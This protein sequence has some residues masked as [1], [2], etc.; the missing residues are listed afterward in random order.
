MATLWN[1]QKKVAAI[2][3]VIFCTL[4]FSVE[5]FAGLSSLLGAV[6]LG[7][8]LHKRWINFLVLLAGYMAVITYFEIAGMAT[9]YPVMFVLVTYLIFAMFKNIEK[10][11]LFFWVNLSLSLLF[12]LAM[13]YLER[14]SGF[15]TQ[16]INGA[17]E[18]IKVMSTVLKEVITEKEFSEFTAFALQ[19]LER[20]HIFFALL[21]IVVFTAL[22]FLLLPLI[23]ENLPDAFNQ[24]FYKLSIPY[25][26]IW[27]LNVGLI[28]YLFQTGKVAIYGINA[29]LFFL[30]IYFF[31]GLS[32]SSAFFKKYGVPFY[33]SLIFFTLFLVNQ[34]MWLLVSIAG[35]VDSQFNIKKFLKEA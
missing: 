1:D 29:V 15:V 7:L 20:Y 34:A 5:L 16:T 18:E 8:L 27:G 3:F 9:L 23:F 28:V 25:Y 14:K 11:E 32:L 30:A 10:G 22:N 24:P 13:F 33:V 4:L 2:V 31:Q 17:K 12:I 35:I 19:L 6:L 21:Q 26:G